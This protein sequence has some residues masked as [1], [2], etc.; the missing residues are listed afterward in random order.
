VLELIEHLRES[1][2][3]IIVISHNIDVI[4]DVADRIV[5][6]YVGRHVATFERVETSP[7]EVV[8]AILGVPFTSADRRSA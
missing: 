8:S 7:E 6:L 3:G 2:L 1:G 5:V 4:F